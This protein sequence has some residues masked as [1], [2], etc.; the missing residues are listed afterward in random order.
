MEQFVILLVIVFSLSGEAAIEITDKEY[1]TLEECTA[2]VEEYWPS[3]MEAVDKNH[4]D[5]T[6]ENKVL[7]MEAFCKQDINEP[8][9]DP[10]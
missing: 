6:V 4:N 1:D 5:P 2:A 10:V 8:A 3:W 7:R 9:G